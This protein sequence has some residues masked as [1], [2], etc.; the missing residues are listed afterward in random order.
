MAIDVIAKR[1]VDPNTK[2][3]LHGVEQARP[4][5]MVPST[6]KISLTGVMALIPGTL[7]DLPD[8]LT[9]LAMD[10]DQA[11]GASAGFFG[12]T[13][14][15]FVKKVINGT[16]LPED[17]PSVA[18][19]YAT[20]SY[21][22]FHNGNGLPDGWN[23]CIK[24]DGKFMFK[25]SGEH[26]IVWDGSVLRI[27]GRLEATEI[28]VGS[29]LTVNGSI[30]AGANIINNTGINIYGAGLS[31]YTSGGLQMGY[32]YGDGQGIL[33]T[34]NRAVIL[35]PGTGYT[36]HAASDLTPSFDEGASLGD[37]ATRWFRGY[38]SH[39]NATG[40]VIMSGLPTSD[41]L[42]AGRLWNSSGTVK[43]S[44]G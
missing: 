26:Y 9:R 34:S 21:F 27:A 15:G 17:N 20:N 43:V 39:L 7:D 37:P 30:I 42:S 28:A 31:L 3:H 18:G 10:D 4:Q 33:V 32:V 2:W 24:S 1:K 6:D 16:L 22:G 44:A 25:G 19:L 8:G 40:E 23:V 11:I 35:A 38:F 41:P 29:T 12:L 13:S 14:E 36:I 5:G